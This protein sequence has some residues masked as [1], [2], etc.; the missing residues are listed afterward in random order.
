MLLLLVAWMGVTTLG[1]IAFTPKSGQ[2]CRHPESSFDGDR[3]RGGRSH[4]RG[5]PRDWCW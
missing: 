4:P 3:S 1:A 5:N 2:I